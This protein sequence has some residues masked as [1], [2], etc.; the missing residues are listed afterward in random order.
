MVQDC[1]I[2]RKADQNSRTLSIE[3]QLFQ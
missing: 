3:R 2:L 1:A